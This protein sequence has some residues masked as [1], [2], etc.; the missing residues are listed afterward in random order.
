MGFLFFLLFVA[1]LVAT[2]FA[3]LRF[4][5]DDISFRPAGLAGLLAVFLVL[6]GWLSYTTVDSGTMGVVTRYGSVTRTVQPGLHFVAPFIDEVHAISTRT[7]VVKPSEDASSKDLQLVHMQVTLAYHF[8]SAYASYFYTQLN[9]SSENAV[10]NK[11]VIPA[12]LEAMKS[13]SALYDAPELITKRPTVR[14]G[15]ETFLQA[16]LAAYHIIPE[17]VSITD[18][19]F[20]KEYNDAIE[21]K[22]TAE[23]QAQ[24]A[25]NVLKKVKIQA[26]QQVAQAQGEA[27]ALKAQK[28]QITP[29]LL[30]LRMIEMLKE[31]WNGELPTNYYGGQAPLPIVEAFRSTKTKQ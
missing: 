21:A 9:D 16:K 6:S 22:Q 18:F 8:D 17:T 24:Q 27:A 29:E 7:L 30:Q 25:E 11:V 15:I 1:S 23:Q 26:E 28:E 14:D 10:E 31:K 12:V 13:Q 4:G 19:N 20:S 3:C 5:K 2:V